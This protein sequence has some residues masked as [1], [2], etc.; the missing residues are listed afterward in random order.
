MLFGDN[1]L[2]KAEKWESKPLGEGLSV[3]PNGLS[4]FSVYMSLK[5]E[6]FSGLPWGL[7]KKKGPCLHFSW[8][9]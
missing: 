5:K 9:L 3:F 7:P 8:P 4:F 2:S 1:G 6:N